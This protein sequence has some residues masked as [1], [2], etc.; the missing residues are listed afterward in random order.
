M[1]SMSSRFDQLSQAAPAFRQI[2]IGFL[3]SHI[4]AEQFAADRLELVLQTPAPARHQRASAAAT[5]ASATS[6][7]VRSAPPASSSGMT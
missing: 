2:E 3:V 1:R 7:V 6:I 4:Q 5:M